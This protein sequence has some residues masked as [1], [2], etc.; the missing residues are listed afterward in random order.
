VRVPLRVQ[1]K[2]FTGSRETVPPGIGNGVHG[3]D[4]I[5]GSRGRLLRLQLLRRKRIANPCGEW[6]ALCFLSG[7]FSS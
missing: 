3:E 1:P 5:L 2:R 6:L 7:E 4:S